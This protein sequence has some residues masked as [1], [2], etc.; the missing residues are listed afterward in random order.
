MSK[1]RDEKIDE[2]EINLVIQVKNEINQIN[3]KYSEF[4][5]SLQALL[6]DFPDEFTLE[7]QI[8]RNDDEIVNQGFLKKY[9]LV[10]SGEEQQIET[11]VDI[12]KEE[13]FQS[14]NLKNLNINQLIENINSHNSK[15]YNQ[16]IE[17]FNKNPVESNSSSMVVENMRQQITDLK[18]EIRELKKDIKENQSEIQKKNLEVITLTTEKAGLFTPE[19]LNNKIEDAVKNVER[20]Y[21]KQQTQFDDVDSK[22]REKKEELSKQELEMRIAQIKNGIKNSKDSETDKILAEVLKQKLPGVFDKGLDLLMMGSSN[23]SQPNNIAS[24]AT[25]II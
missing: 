6:T 1:L 24:I 2:D 19:Q 22:I 14:D 3:Y 21:K 25:E 13:T 15:F 23:M 10:S 8:I 4:P 5:E 20:N 18:D 12:K 7:Y 17:S 9:S 16:L 11:K